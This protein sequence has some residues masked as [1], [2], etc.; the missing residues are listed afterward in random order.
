MIEKKEIIEACKQLQQKRRDEA[1]TYTAAINKAATEAEAAKAKA[2][3][4]ISAGDQSAY[5]AAVVAKRKAEDVQEYQT[6]RLKLFE[7][8]SIMD[9]PEFQIILAELKAYKTAAE[10]EHEKHRL[11][12]ERAIY[13]E[14]KAAWDIR[15]DYLAAFNAMREICPELDQKCPG[16]RNFRY[17]IDTERE[18]S[19]YVTYGSNVA[20]VKQRVEAI[21]KEAETKSKPSK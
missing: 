7:A 20:E 16:L 12:K 13:L 2:A 9:N 3:A 18:W 11:E 6:G 8:Q 10:A 17:Q 19:N 4:A 14:A 5:L 15:Q 1:N 21:L